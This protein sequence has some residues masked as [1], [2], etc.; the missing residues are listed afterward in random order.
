MSNHDLDELSRSIEWE[1][2]SA[3]RRITARRQLLQTVG[4]G[5]PRPAPSQYR[6]IVPAMVTFALASAG[7]W[8]AVRHHSSTATTTAT[9]SIAE[10]RGQIHPSLG[11]SFE[12]VGT[13]GHELVRVRHGVMR[14]SVKPLQDTEF[15][16]VAV[17]SDIVEVHGTVFNVTAI[18]NE[19]VSV[20]VVRGRV[21]VLLASGK[22]ISLR[23]GQHWISPKIIKKAMI[24]SPEPSN[25]GVKK[26]AN[27]NP[28]LQQ[29]ANSNPS[30][31]Q[32]NKGTTRQTHR[33]P[34]FL[35]REQLSNPGSSLSKQVEGDGKANAST[36]TEA[37][38]VDT[39]DPPPEFPGEADFQT[40]WSAFEH[41]DFGRAA[42][43]LD[44]SCRSARAVTLGEDACFWHAVAL[45]RAGRPSE[46]RAHF[47]R[48]LTRWPNSSRSN[49][50]RISLGWLLLATGT[51][52]DAKSLFEAANDDL[53]PSVRA[54]A[55]R[56]LQAIEQR[57]KEVNR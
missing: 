19:L 26:D 22:N 49:E 50:A 2:P 18:A 12:R 43:I 29:D 11:A 37:I 16:R 24:A 55:R 14:F 33:S 30:L 23:P 52:S 38:P 53:A 51:P 20:S 48:Y 32:A 10:Y 5:Q 44:R 54:S 39:P 57:G 42:A 46:A 6:R 40:G 56:G 25:A 34:P 15:F 1:H 45:E 27:S 35:R 4:T 47:R 41:G 17:G 8:L 31:Q 13:P 28:S 3:K 36:G 7:I 9:P 21:T